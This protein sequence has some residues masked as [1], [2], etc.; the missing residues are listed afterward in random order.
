[1]MS[2]FVILNQSKLKPKKKARIAP[3][4]KNGAKGI[5]LFIVQFFARTVLARMCENYFLLLSNLKS[6]SI[7]NLTNSLKDVFGFQPSIFFALL[8]SPT[9]KSTSA[10]LK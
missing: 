4:T 1:M 5:S 10:G 7:I 2:K 8:A 3:K 6:A 9:S